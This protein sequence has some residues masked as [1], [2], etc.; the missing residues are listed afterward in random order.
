MDDR[1]VDLVG[2]GIDIALRMG[3]LQDSSLVARKIGQSPRGVT[4]SPKY[5]EQAGEPTSPAE[6]ASHQ[7]VVYD[8]LSG[9]LYGI[10]PGAKMVMNLVL[11]LNMG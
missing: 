1:N 9:G 2:A 11:R 4:A 7:A 3:D 5:L 10:S 6:R 8:L